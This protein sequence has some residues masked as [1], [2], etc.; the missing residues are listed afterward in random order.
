MGYYGVAPIAFESVS[1]VTATPSVEVGT[2]RED[3]DEKYVYVYNAGNSQISVGKCAVVSAVS[4]YSV[5]VSS[6]S[7][8][9]AVGFCKHATLTT[10]TYGWLVTRGFVDSVTN[11]MASTALA[12]GDVVQVGIDG[13]V[14]KGVTGPSVGKMMTA[15]GSAGAAH[16]F[17]CVF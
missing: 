11:A 6:V 3:G 12:A 10:G 9:F 2:I 14:A 15:T 17:V 13:G 8:D 16:A 4:G 1:A 7:G 5:T